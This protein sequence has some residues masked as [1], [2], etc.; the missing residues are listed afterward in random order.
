MG[1]CTSP[2]PILPALAIWKEVRILFSMTYDLQEFQFVADTLAAGHVEP[3]DMI[4]DRISL[5]KL[6]EMLETLRKPGP[7]VKVMVDPWA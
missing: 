7:Q 4:T 5:D 2:D 6:P 1:F 3:R